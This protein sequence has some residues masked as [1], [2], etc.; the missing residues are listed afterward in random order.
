MKFL[1]ITS[2]IAAAIIAASCSGKE[3]AADNEASGKEML[4]GS[5]KLERA[6]KENAATGI[7]YANEHVQVILSLRPN[8]YFLVYDS[9]IDPA[10]K[11][12]GVPLITE[13]LKGQWE[14]KNEQLTLHY[15]GDST[16]SETLE[17][18]KVDGSTLVTKGKNQQSSVFKTYGRK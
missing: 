16:Y 11:E 8:G 6:N 7:A 1:S 17:I 15:S 9:V 13:R 14:R 12:K 4:T 5:W 2:L 3:K 18:S 10:W